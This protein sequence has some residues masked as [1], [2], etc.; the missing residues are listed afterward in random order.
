MN[1]SKNVFTQQINKTLSAAEIIKTTST[2]LAYKPA[3]EIVYTWKDEEQDLMGKNEPI[4]N[5]A[6]EY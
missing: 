5:Y 2:T 1:Q 6:I 4:K 3:F